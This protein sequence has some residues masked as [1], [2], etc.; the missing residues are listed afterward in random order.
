MST[1][2]K[3]PIPNSSFNVKNHENNKCLLFLEFNSEIAWQL[4]NFARDWV[5][6]NPF[7]LKELY[8]AVIDVSLVTG[9]TLFRAPATPGTVLDNDSWTETKKNTVRRTDG[10]S[11]YNYFKIEGKSSFSL[12]DFNCDIITSCVSKGG[13]IPIRVK[14]LDCMVGMLTISGTNHLKDHVLAYETLEAFPK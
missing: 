4:G 1:I 5:L 3:M 9:H 8:T 6:Q 13:S 10:Y 7:K 11:L 14:G 2:Y 12:Y